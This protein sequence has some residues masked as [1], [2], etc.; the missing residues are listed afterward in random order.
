MTIPKLALMLVCL[1]PVTL[2]PKDAKVTTLFSK[3]LPDVPGKGGLMLTVEILRAPRTP[4][5]ATTQM[6]LFMC[7]RAQS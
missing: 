2:A 1:A 3:D 7:L 6:R 5:I 4:C